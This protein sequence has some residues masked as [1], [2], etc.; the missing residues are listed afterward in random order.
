MLNP[1]SKSWDQDKFIK[2][3]IYIYRASFLTYPMLKIEIEKTNLIHEIRITSYKKNWK[4]IM[5]SNSQNNLILK[6]KIEK[7]LNKKK[8]WVIGGWN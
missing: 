7:K 1:P 3:Y 6:V 5:K 4:N 2:K 8:H